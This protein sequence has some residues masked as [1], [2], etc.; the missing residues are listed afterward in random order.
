MLCPYCGIPM[1]AV[2]YDDAD[3]DCSGVRTFYAC[4]RCDYE[5]TLCDEQDEKE[6][7]A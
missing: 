1:T 3:A 6:T 7:G 5:D 4:D 2:D